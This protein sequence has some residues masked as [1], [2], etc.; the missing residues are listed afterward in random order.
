MFRLELQ[1]QNIT[2]KE[3]TLK[4]GKTLTI[5]RHTDNDIVLKDGA[6]SR[7]HASIERKG[8][9]LFVYDKGSRNGTW[10]NGNRAQSAELYN[11]DIVRIGKELSVKVATSSSVK[12]E[13]TLTGEHDDPASTLQTAANTSA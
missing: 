1:L 7:Y 6:V 13:S 3:Y 5:G 2:L 4:D 11:E 10:V 12:K 8:A 9:K